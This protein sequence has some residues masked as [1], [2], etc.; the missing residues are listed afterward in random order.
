MWRTYVQCVRS[1]CS[2]SGFEIKW[3]GLQIDIFHEC[4]YMISG[5]IIESL[6]MTYI[7]PCSCKPASG[8]L[9][10]VD[11]KDSHQSYSDER[12]QACAPIEKPYKSFPLSCGKQN[13]DAVV[14]LRKLLI[15]TGEWKVLYSNSATI[16]RP[17]FEGNSKR[18][19]LFETRFASFDRQSK[20]T[21]RT[22][23]QRLGSP[24][25]VQ[26]RLIKAKRNLIGAAGENSLG[27]AV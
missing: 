4:Q 2:P 24:I 12:N 10:L 18:L 14:D 15:G 20:L 23:S 13:N 25:Q 8:Y 9:L 22:G 16:Q 5:N 21:K 3:Q 1:S 7:P 26:A 17:E 19:R 27:V 6:P 11:K